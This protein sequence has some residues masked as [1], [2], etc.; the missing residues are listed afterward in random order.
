[1]MIPYGELT[2]RK[3]K[4]IRMIKNV[5]QIMGEAIPLVCMQI[6]LNKLEESH[7][8]KTKLETKYHGI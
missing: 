3:I 2:E 1:M 6:G 5:I 4:S 8:Q 7:C